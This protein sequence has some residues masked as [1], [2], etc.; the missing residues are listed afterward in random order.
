M[1]EVTGVDFME[2]SAEVTDG[3]IE[4]ET[5][6]GCVVSCLVGTGGITGRASC[7]SNELKT[8]KLGARWV[9]LKL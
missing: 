5:I 9:V 4:T 3:I 7:A 1:F 8:P 2:L 6:E